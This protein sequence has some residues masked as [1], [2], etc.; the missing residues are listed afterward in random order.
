M[1]LMCAKCVLS[2]CLVTACLVCALCVALVCV[3]L[4]VCT[5]TQTHTH[6]QTQTQTHTHARAPA[7]I[8]GNYTLTRTHTHTDFMIRIMIPGGDNHEE[9]HD[10]HALEDAGLVLQAPAQ[11]DQSS[12]PSQ[13]GGV[14]I[15]PCLSP[16]TY[17]RDVC[18]GCIHCVRVRG[19]MCVSQ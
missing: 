10:T 3:C 6:T 4:C 14:E 9:H 13:H 19:C 5:H 12:H 18:R 17:A 2:V 7:H 11:G 15:I 1:C 8:R 16:H